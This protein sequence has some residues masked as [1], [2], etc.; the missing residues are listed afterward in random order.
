MS[1]TYTRGQIV[2]DSLALAGRGMELKQSCNQWLNYFLIHLS[3]TFRFPELRKVGSAQTLPIGSQ[4]AALPSDFGC[5]MEK[6]GMLF[7][8]DMKPLEETSYEEFAQNYGFFQTGTGNGRPVQYFV[9]REAG[10]FRFNRVA[11]QAYSFT[12][13]YFKQGPLLATDTSSDS[14]KIWLDNDLLAVEGLKWMIYVYTEDP[15]E[16][17]QA[18]KVD[19][20]LIEWKRE[21]VKMGGTSRV[22]PSPSRFKNVKFGGTLG[23]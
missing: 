16:D 20:I 9:D 10:V 8:P 2:T 11:D 6:Q 7:G 21:L 4:T 17:K 15:R 5:G 14:S 3:T 12:P 1:S 13:V 18:M 22:L 23:P 19:K